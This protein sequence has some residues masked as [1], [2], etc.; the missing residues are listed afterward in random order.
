MDKG[1]AFRAMSIYK[2]F[3]VSGTKNVVITIDGGMDKGSAFVH[4]KFTEK[5]HKICL[6]KTYY[7]VEIRL[8]RELAE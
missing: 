2:L 3:L 1:S 7:I 8:K 5:S 4:K 6:Q